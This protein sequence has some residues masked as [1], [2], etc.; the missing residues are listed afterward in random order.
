MTSLVQTSDSHWNFALCQGLL[1]GAT[2]F[3]GPGAHR[4]LARQWAA[5]RE[6]SK[7]A[8]CVETFSCSNPCSDYCEGL[9]ES[10]DLVPIGG[11][12]GSGRKAGLD[13]TSV[14]TFSVLWYQGLLRGAA[15]FP[16]LGA[17]RRLARQWTQG[18][19]DLAVPAGGVGSRV[20]DLHLRVP[21]HV[22]LH[23][24]LL[25]RGDVA[26]LPFAGKGKLGVSIR[27]SC[28]Y[29]AAS[30]SDSSILR[31]PSNTG[32]IAQGHKRKIIAS[33]A[34]AGDG[35]FALLC[36]CHKNCVPPVAQSFAHVCTQSQD[37]HL[38]PPEDAL[39]RVKRCT[40]AH[41]RACG[42]GS[43]SCRGLNPTT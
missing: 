9:R 28:P 24:R 39:S 38:L 19:L 35:I 42:C 36:R 29:A 32:L 18:G 33:G 40:R 30:S 25:R 14:E 16:G 22:R 6:C 26:F 13:S 21:M 15:G 37:L 20:G 41:R 43:C 23:G 1:R 5:W 3:A 11:W 27:L 4:L 2:G 34:G 17:H 10:P 31:W 8:A 7:V 12:H